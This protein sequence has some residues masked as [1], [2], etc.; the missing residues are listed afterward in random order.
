VIRRLVSAA[1]F[2]LATGCSDWISPPVPLGGQYALIA[3]N[4][5]ALPS[6]PFPPNG[7]CLTVQGVLTFGDST[8]ALTV[9]YQDKASPFG[10][11]NTETGRYLRQH[12]TVTFTRTGGSGLNLPFVISPGTISLNGDTVSFRY[13]GDPTNEV[14]AIFHRLP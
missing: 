7:C 9:T 10:F 6:D 3:E 14:H 2:V 4:G 11:S 12:Y 5:K 8:Y 13:I 1:L